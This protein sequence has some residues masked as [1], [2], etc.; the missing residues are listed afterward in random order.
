[1]PDESLPT[2]LTALATLS[3]DLHALVAAGLLAPDAAAAAH[4]QLAKAA[5]LAASPAPLLL[6]LTVHLVAARAAL[7][8]ATVPPAVLASLAQ[9]LALVQHLPPR[10]ERTAWTRPHQRLDG[11]KEIDPRN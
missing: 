3:A 4:A 5:R 7:A 9:A 6:T 11:K 2:L 1:M 8:E 10:P